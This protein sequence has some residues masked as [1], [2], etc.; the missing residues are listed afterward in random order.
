MPQASTDISTEHA[1]RYLQQLCK[2]WSHKMQVEFDPLR[3]R[4][5]FPSGAV[6]MLQASPTGL[7]VLIETDDEQALDQLEVVVAEHIKRFAFRE[8]LPFNWTR[9]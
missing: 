2:H 4:I 6:T 9:H 3:G 5:V 7:A 8:E 1:S